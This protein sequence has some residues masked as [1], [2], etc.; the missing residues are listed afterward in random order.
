MWQARIEEYLHNSESGS[1]RR[2]CF[3]MKKEFFL[4]EEKIEVQKFGPAQYVIVRRKCV[5][6]CYLDYKSAWLSLD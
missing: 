2:V 5:C 6:I 3:A 4:R 1:H